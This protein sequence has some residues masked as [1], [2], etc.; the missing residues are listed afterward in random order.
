M[1]RDLLLAIRD[2]DTPGTILEPGYRWRRTPWA[3]IEAAD[4]VDFGK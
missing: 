1:L 2:I 3:P 4:L